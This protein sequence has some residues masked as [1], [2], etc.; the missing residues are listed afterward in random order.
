MSNN[1]LNIELHYVITKRIN[2]EGDVIVNLTAKMTKEEFKELEK[3]IID[4]YGVVINDE[5]F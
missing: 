2:A 5:S 3:M 4:E 1:D